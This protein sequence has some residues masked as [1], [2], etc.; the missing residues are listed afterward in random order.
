M[1][2]YKYIVWENSGPKYQLYVICIAI[3]TLLLKK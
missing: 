1:D 2:S 3:S